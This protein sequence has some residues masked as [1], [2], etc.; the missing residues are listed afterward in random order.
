[1]A[2]HL[3]ARSVF[4][5]LSKDSSANIRVIAIDTSKEVISAAVS[6]PGAAADHAA[7]QDRLSTTY[8]VQPPNLGA[9]APPAAK[10]TS[11]ELQVQPHDP[12]MATSQGEARHNLGKLYSCCMQAY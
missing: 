9:P 1:M 12:A 10:D 11:S 3:P 8:A 5:T 4:S 6:K 2:Y 7:G